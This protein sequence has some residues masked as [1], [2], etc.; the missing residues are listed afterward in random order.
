MTATL[1]FSPEGTGYGLYTEAIDLLLLGALHIERA[2][3][4]EFDNEDQMWR[5]RDTSGTALYAAARRQECLDWER[6]HVMPW[7]REPPETRQLTCDYR[8]RTTQ[9]QKG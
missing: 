2:T 5:V 4:I 1:I 6:E 9:Q 3:E 8:E 7:G